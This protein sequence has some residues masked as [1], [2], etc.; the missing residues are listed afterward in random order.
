MKTDK[1][2]QIKDWQT[3][4]DAPW[5]A[6]CQKD[7]YSKIKKQEG[8]KGPRSLT[9]GKGQGKAIYRGPLMLSTKYW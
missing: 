7:D 2:Y 5:T 4:G 9:W 6:L 3:S 8:P 1:L